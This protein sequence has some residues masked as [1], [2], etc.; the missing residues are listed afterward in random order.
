MIRPFV[1]NFAFL[2]LLGCQPLYDETSTNHLITWKVQDGGK[3]AKFKILQYLNIHGKAIDCKEPFEV[4]VTVSMELNP[5]A[6]GMDITVAREQARAKAT[7]QI[8]DKEKRQI[9]QNTFLSTSSY[10]TDPKEEFASL[11][12]K[13]SAKER[14]LISLASSIAREVAVVIKQR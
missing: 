14:L 6:Y 8:Y 3:F 4:K 12:S 5:L 7:I 11:S 2:I 10:N 1:K 9:Y 13:E